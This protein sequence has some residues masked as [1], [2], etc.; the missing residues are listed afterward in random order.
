MV[1]ARSYT[2]EFVSQ[3]LKEIKEVGSSRIVA[4]KH[5]LPESTVYGWSKGKTPK[6][7]GPVSIGKERFHESENKALKKLLTDKDL[8]ISILR[9]LLKKTY[10]V[11]D[12]EKK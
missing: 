1:M 6:V 8:E 3:I 2:P 9:D 5:N 11:F 10:Q 4:Q 12:T 7:T